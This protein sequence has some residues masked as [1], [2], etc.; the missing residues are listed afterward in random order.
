MI[1]DPVVWAKIT[2]EGAKYPL[3]YMTYAATKFKVATSNGLG[4]ETFTRKVKDGCTDGR[5]YE[6]ILVAYF[7]T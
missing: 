1:F 4:G 3:H 6:W 2:Q 5:S 7:L